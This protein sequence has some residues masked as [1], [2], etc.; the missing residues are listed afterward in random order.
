MK[1]EVWQLFWFF[2]TPELTFP[3]IIFVSISATIEVSGH[4][5]YVEQESMLAIGS[6]KWHTSMWIYKD[7]IYVLDTREYTN[8]TNMNQYLI[9]ILIF[10]RLMS[11]VLEEDASLPCFLEQSQLFLGLFRSFF[12]W[13]HLRKVDNDQPSKLPNR[14]EHFLKKSM[15]I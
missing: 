5:H 6:F 14:V 9:N 1:T 7:L 13:L 12:C 3:F 2:Y 10:Y 4:S 11:P 8:V 15:E